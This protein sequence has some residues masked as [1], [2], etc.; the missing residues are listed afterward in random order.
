M[1]H[2][3]ISVLPN[4]KAI[5][6]KTWNA[7]HQT[8]IFY[9]GGDHSKNLIER[10]ARLQASVNGENIKAD[11]F[12]ISGSGVFIGITHGTAPPDRNFNEIASYF[13]SAAK[14]A[15]YLVVQGTTPGL[16]ELPMIEV[17]DMV[18][19]LKEIIEII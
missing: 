3:P 5:D 15:M 14:Y 1:Q 2:I 4:S 13:A 16:P 9:K 8:A 6:P 7:A 19:T 10:M 18:S 12:T 11:I 17:E